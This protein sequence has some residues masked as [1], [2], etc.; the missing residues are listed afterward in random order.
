MRILGIILIVLG[1]VALVYK[2][3]SYT[4]ERTLIDVG[5]IEAKVDE[6]KTVPLSPL[7]GGGA[8]IAGIVLVIA[9]RR[10][11]TA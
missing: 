8:V 2:G 9:D 1:L 5:P 4:K 6:R 7:V 10:R 3:F 11:S